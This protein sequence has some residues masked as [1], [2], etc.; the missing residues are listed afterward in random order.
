MVVAK[1]F[2]NRTQTPFWVHLNRSGT[3]GRLG[4]KWKRNFANPGSE[5]PAQTPVPTHRYKPRE[6]R[7]QGYHESRG[8]RHDES[9]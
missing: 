2:D 6:V 1:I 3:P 5:L 8:A 7:R 4:T 9:W